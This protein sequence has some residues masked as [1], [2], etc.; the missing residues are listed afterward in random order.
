VKVDTFEM[1]DIFGKVDTFEKPDIFWKVDIFDGEFVEFANV[2]FKET[3]KSLVFEIFWR[4][5]LKGVF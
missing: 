2:S 3:L 4:E 1:P 5:M